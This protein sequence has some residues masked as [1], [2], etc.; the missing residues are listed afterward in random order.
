M[1][2]DKGHSVA[3]NLPGVQQ[4]G[5]IADSRMTDTLLLETLKVCDKAFEK[6]EALVPDPVIVGSGADFSYRYEQRTYA[7]MKEVGTD[8][9]AYDEHGELLR[10]FREMSEG[11]SLPSRSALKNSPAD[12]PTLVQYQGEVGWCYARA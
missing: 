1:S 6:L 5:R 7:R 4:T 8:W 9:T 11:W 12:Q 2:S 3:S 10:F